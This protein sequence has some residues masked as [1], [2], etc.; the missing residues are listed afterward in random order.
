MSN[1]ERKVSRFFKG[2]LE[3]EMAFSIYYEV[4][5]FKS[6]FFKEVKI[7]IEDCETKW[8]P[9]NKHAD[10]SFVPKIKKIDEDTNEITLTRSQREDILFLLKI[11]MVF[12]T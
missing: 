3:R 11:V 10:S 12:L 7:T 8:K 6:S 4:T 2:Y 1:A 9:S 5:L